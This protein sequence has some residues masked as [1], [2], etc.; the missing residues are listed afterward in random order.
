MITLHHL[1]YSQS[2]RILWLL[3]ELEAEYELKKYDRDPA[4]RLAPAELKALSPLGTSPVITGEND[5]VLAES[6]AVIDY[7]LDLHRE[8]H[9]RPEFGAPSR[10]NYLFW[11]HAG[12]GSLMPMQFM[13]GILAMMTART[14]ALLRPVVRGVTGKVRAMLLEPR[15]KVIFDRMEK[16]LGEH[17]W[18]AA[19]HM[20]AADISLSYSIFSAEARGAF[21][22]RP[23]IRRW[24]EQV[25]ELPSFQRAMEKDGRETMVFSF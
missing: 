20:T 11:F 10:A 1:E 5:L 15:L 6:N 22:D 9:L 25:R 7:V 17:K 24:L 12:N 2:F 14:P 23:H 18:L 8:S 16:D 21:E 3:E 13:N 19:E 4:T